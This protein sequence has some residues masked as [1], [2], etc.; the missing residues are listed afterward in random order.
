MALNSGFREVRRERAAGSIGARKFQTAVVRFRNPAGDG[1]SQSCA[2]RVALRARPRLIHPEKSLEDS[3]LQIRR[4][5][6]AGIRY[7]HDVPLTLLAA[8][9]AN[10]PT[11]RRV[12]EGVVQNVKQQSPNQG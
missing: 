2:A 9:H 12:L 3:S 4:D 6:R 1:K 8:L 10:V 5:T 11:T 7:G